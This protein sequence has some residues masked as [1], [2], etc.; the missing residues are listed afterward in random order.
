MTTMVQTDHRLGGDF[1]TLWHSRS[2]DDSA[3]RRPVPISTGRGRPV[4]CVHWGS[5]NI[6][7]ARHATERWAANRP[8]FGFEAVGLYDTSRPLLSVDEMAERYLHEMRL[9]Q[10]KGPYALVGV[11]S[12]SQIAFEMAR[13]LTAQGEGVEVLVVVNGVCPGVSVFNPMWTLEDIF[14]LRLASLRRDFDAGDLNAHVPEVL[15]ALKARHWIDEYAGVEDFY[16]HQLVWA[17]GAYA[18]ENYTSRFYDGP[19]HAFRSTDVRGPGEVP[20]FG[21]A[22]TVYECVVDADDSIAIMRHPEFTRIFARSLK[23]S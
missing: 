18:Q 11:C 22:A 19:L 23:G 8:V 1:G 6:R 13:R 21:A 16:R 20:W 2:L 14:E 12:G 5:G 4:F 17:A 3:L 10:P 7:F 15:A 9:M